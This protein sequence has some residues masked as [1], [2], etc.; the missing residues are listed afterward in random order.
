[1]ARRKH[2]HRVKHPSPQA[3]PFSAFL[4]SVARTQC[5]DAVAHLSSH[6]G[7]AVTLSPYERECVENAIASW[8]EQAL[9]SGERMKSLCAQA[10][11]TCESQ[12]NQLVASAVQCELMDSS[13]VM[14]NQTT[15]E[16]GSL[17][18]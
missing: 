1:M 12:V 6:R 7:S 5:D 3:D 4:K 17:E 9:C 14:S 2:H 10:G 13:P 15:L 16:G 11:V 18:D 8:I